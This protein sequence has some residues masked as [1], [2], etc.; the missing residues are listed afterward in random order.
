VDTLT[1][2]LRT[3]AWLVTAAILAAATV[4]TSRSLGWPLTWDTAMTHYVAARTI[5]GAVPYRDLF[6]TG[7]P[8]LYL[9]H[10]AALHL[11]GPSD[12]GFRVFDL[13][14]L[15]GILTGLAAVLRP[16][17]ALAMAL[18]VALF[19]LFHVAGGAWRAGQRDMVL[20]FPLIWAM[21]MA[22]ADHRAPRRWTIG[23][24]GVAFGVAVWIKPYAGLFGAL[25]LPLLARREASE[26]WSAALVAGLGF[27]LPAAIVIAWLGAIGGLGPFLDFLFGYLLPVYSQLGGPRTLLDGLLTLGGLGLGA[28]VGTVA[29]WRAGYLRGAGV[30]L[31]LG[32][33]YG[34]LHYVIQGKGWE[35]HLYPF[36]LFAI[37][38][39]VAG[40]TSAL[41]HGRTVLAGLAL[42]VVLALA[43]GMAWKGVRNLDPPWLAA[44]E[45]MISGV[46]GD[47][48]PAIQAGHAVQVL[49]VTN[50]GAT[51]LYR[52]GI[53]SPTR[54]ISDFPLFRQAGRPY[55][56]QLRAEFVETL[57][58]RPPEVIVI[59]SQSGD[60][61][62][63]R[64]RRFPAFQEFLDARYRLGHEA[65]GYRIY[66]ARGAS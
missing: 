30:L 27:V 26:R 55:V 3:I 7:F 13:G 61:G 38:I 44:H 58:R 33:A 2:T 17:G 59:F 47:L 20:C 32:V 62:Y 9:V 45:A 15:A 54:I 5:E 39:G 35:Y 23:L 60:D 48:R 24:A 25:F 4:L 6:E 8:G 65:R 14:V 11:L 51:V 52:A 18:G 19:W 12:A 43:G 42:A 22:L 49:D 57:R 41:A 16:F 28:L 37:V 36:A 40:T 29:L 66:L 46:L 50:A 34:A 21:A 63:R 56:Q 31:C 10:I 1:G 64:V 53:P